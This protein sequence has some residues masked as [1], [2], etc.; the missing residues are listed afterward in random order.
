MVGALVPQDI[1][2]FVDEPEASISA[3]AVL[4]DSVWI[5]SFG[6]TRHPP[7]RE[8]RAR[9]PGQAEGAAPAGAPGQKI[10]VLWPQLIF[11]PIGQES[12]R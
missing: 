11:S 7:D 6:E 2:R 4:S 8:Q 3:A 1:E 10:G 9:A 12:I 5:E